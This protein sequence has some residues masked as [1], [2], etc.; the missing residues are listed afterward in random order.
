MAWSVL[1]IA[2][3]AMI[4]LALQTG[5]RVWKMRG[6]RPMAAMRGPKPANR[7]TP[8]HQESADATS[9]NRRRVLEEGWKAARS[10]SAEARAGLNLLT[11]AALNPYAAEPERSRWTEGFTKALEG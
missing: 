8:T 6:G 7:A 9:R 5:W 2:V 3:V 11:M 10:L 4:L 1:T